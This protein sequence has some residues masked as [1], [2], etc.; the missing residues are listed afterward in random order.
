MGMLLTV[1]VVAIVNCEA[2]RAIIHFFS[3]VPDRIG[4][5]PDPHRGCAPQARPAVQ[6]FVARPASY[7]RGLGLRDARVK[8]FFLSTRQY[9][10]DAPVRAIRLA[11]A[12]RLIVLFVA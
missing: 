4:S 10:S 11:S 5:G 12:R 8:L 6:E 3:M 2:R 7:S 9:K 1:T